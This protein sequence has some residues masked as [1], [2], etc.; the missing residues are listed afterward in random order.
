MT[1]V[2]IEDKF[3]YAYE[4]DRAALEGE[5]PSNFCH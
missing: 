4:T 2:M 1:T 5:T 3:N